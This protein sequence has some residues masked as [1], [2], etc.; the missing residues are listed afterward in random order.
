MEVLFANII[1][2]NISGCHRIFP[3][4]EAYLIPGCSFDLFRAKQWYKRVLRNA[5]DQFAGCAG[6]LAQIEF[7]CGTALRLI[8]QTGL[9]LCIAVIHFCRCVI[10]EMMELAAITAVGYA[11]IFDRH[12]FFKCHQ[13]CS[14]FD[15]FF[16]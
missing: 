4:G 10:T 12:S 3:D 15:R 7:C 1:T 16:V 11:D 5:G 8:G 13:L 6:C 9:C 2:G 14:G